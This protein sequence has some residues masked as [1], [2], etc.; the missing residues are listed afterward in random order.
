MFCS[1]CGSRVEEG[2]KFCTNCGAKLENDAAAPVNGQQMAASGPSPHIPNQNIYAGAQ[3]NPQMGQEQN[4]PFGYN[5]PEFMQD[6]TGQLPPVPPMPV[7]EETA[8]AGK[9]RNA[10]KIWIPIV[11]AL[12]I[13]CITGG[14]IVHILSR[15]FR[16]EIREFQAGMKAYQLGNLADEYEEVLAGAEEAAAKRQI[17]KYEGEKE[18][19]AAIREKIVS[20]NEKVEGYLEKYNE[21]T[22]E[23]EKSGQYILDD[24][25]RQ[26]EKTRDKF[27]DALDTFDEVACE[28]LEEDFEELQEKIIKANEESGQEWL[29]LAKD[30][31]EEW[32][33]CERYLLAQKKEEVEKSYSSKQYKQEKE[34]YDGFQELE[35]GFQKVRNTS[36]VVSTYS[37]ADVSTKGKIQLYFQSEEE[38]LTW[39]L[40]DFTIYEQ[41]GENWE[42]CEPVDISQIRDKGDLSIDL[43][44]DVSTSME[45]VFYDMQNAVSDFAGSVHSNVRLGLS[46]LSSVYTRKNAFTTDSSTIQ[47]A[48]NNLIC[49][50]STAL[51]ESLYSSVLYT[52]K[53]KGARCVIAFTDGVN[54][55]YDST[56]DYTEQDV[57]DVAKRYKVP[58][59]LIGIGSGIAE[60]VLEEIAEETGGGYQYLSWDR[61]GQMDEFYME[62]YEK[63]MAMY[64]LT[65]SSVIQDYKDRNVYISYYDDAQNVSM[66]M[67]DEVEVSTLA[68]AYNEVTT[69]DIPSY[70]TKSYALSTENL[71]VLVEEYGFEGIQKL[72]NVYFAKNGYKFGSSEFGKRAL[73]EMKDLGVITKNGKH[74]SDYAEKKMKKHKQL[75]KNFYMVYRYRDSLLYDTMYDIYDGY[76]SKKEVLEQTYDRLGIQD[77]FTKKRFKSIWDSTY[78]KVKKD[79]KNLY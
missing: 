21:I 66:H 22:E 18:N 61:V 74:T 33:G 15:N 67:E 17:W 51:Y 46:E 43:V 68:S 60:D 77:S 53:A 8:P 59:Y 37:Q 47:S 2:L 42:K 75:F 38:N 14:V 50:G 44:A 11:A 54:E 70:Y 41:V 20:M 12:V 27:K 79:Q 76:L 39:K 19:L 69:D 57:I 4:Q 16:G 3:G 72:I 28:S 25:E 34:A 56:R 62:I 6:F 29:E 48:V 23:L 7:Q 64:Q 9:K 52:A 13:L 63:Q 30:D 36:E 78:K 32:S 1:Q 73:Q 10:K 24:Y 49:H 55:A 35:A 5:Q 40:S 65:Y 71:D 58:I 26:Y 31:I 45:D